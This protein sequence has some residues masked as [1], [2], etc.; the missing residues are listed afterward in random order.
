MKNY[1]EN[2]QESETQLPQNWMAINGGL[3]KQTIHELANAWQG[4]SGPR[5][6]PQHLGG[7][8]NTFDPPQGHPG[9]PSGARFSSSCRNWTR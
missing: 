2:Q 8:L 7:R 4:W 9:A 5:H 1:M 6:F 3:V